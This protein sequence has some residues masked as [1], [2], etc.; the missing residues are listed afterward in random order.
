LWHCRQCK[1]TI[2]SSCADSWNNEILS[3]S[4]CTASS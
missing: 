3:K 1:E 4:M 2:F